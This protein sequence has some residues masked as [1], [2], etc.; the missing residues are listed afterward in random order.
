VLYS[1]DN[2]GREVK[3]EKN[4]MKNIMGLSRNVLLV[5]VAIGTLSALLSAPNSEA[6]TGPY[7]EYLGTQSCGSRGFVSGMTCY[8]AEVENC[9]GDDTLEFV[10]GVDNP[11]GT[12]GTIV[13]FSGGSGGT[14]PTMRLTR[15]KFP[16]T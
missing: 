14:L 9:P 10:Y 16:F 2:S 11:T 3:K 15:P 1:A 12:A 6:Q 8:L 4:I 7:V 5:C 13:M